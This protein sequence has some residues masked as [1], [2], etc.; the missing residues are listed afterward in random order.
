V[1]S[2]SQ[3]LVFSCALSF[4]SA[5]AA[6]QTPATTFEVASVKPNKSGSTQVTTNF[7][8]TAVTLIN[9]QLR[10]II[11]F[12]WG[13]NTPSR[14]V[15]V[16]DWAN[17]ERFDV[18]G[19]AD[20]IPSREAMRPMLQALL[21]ERFKLATHMEQRDQP[22]YAL[23]RARRD[24]TLGSGL[25]LST[26]TCAGRGA[27]PPADGASPAV[28]CGPRPGGPGRLVIVGMPLAQLAPIL[29]LMVGRTVVDKTG[30]TERYDIEL[31]FTPDR[32]LP[33]PDGTPAPAPT[34]SGPSLFTALQE[35]LGLKLDPSKET[36]DV[37][38]IDHVERPT[39]N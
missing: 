22:L 24:G 6:A 13:I 27:P 10:P 35:Q 11:Q 33:G 14:L 30:L 8:T 38:V 1:K 37:L 26:V 16:P 18:I 9:L 31:T 34:D 4:L 20:S 12:A 21:A 29:S 39:E 2:R 25:R 23:V 32:P 28:P 15:G 17:V 36:V 3:R 7:G 5:F 19:K